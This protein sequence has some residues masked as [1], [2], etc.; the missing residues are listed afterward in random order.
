LGI[1]WSGPAGNQFMIF[2]DDDNTRTPVEYTLQF[3]PTDEQHL[4][5]NLALALPYFK[6]MNNAIIKMK[7]I[8][9][10]F[11]YELK[12]QIIKNTNNN[13]YKLKK[14]K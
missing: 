6:L 4:M 14:Y 13:K 8:H 5:D 3:I 2:G 9:T 12:I 11:Q 7:K 1:P 10:N